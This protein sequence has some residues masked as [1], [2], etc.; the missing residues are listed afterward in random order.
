[1]ASSEALHGRLQTDIDLKSSAE[2]YYK[3]WRKEA[4]KIPTATGQNIQAITLHEGDWHD[5][6]AIK[7]WNYTVGCKEKMQ[8]SEGLIWVA[9]EMYHDNINIPQ[10]I[11]EDINLEIMNN[12]I[13]IYIYIYI[14]FLT[15]YASECV[16]GKSGVFKEKVEF[17]D[18]SMTITLH[19]IEGDVYNEYKVYRPIC[20]VVPKNRGSVA[21]LVIE[22]ERVNEDAPI[23]NKF[24]DLFVSM[25]KDIDAHA[26]AA[27][28]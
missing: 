27:S 2:E 26:Y 13:Y 19:G 21:K 20:K 17:D 10:H 25:T 8:E 9:A 12:H 7:I 16:D 28:T 24:M 11:Y 14:Q 6:G 22:Y 4:H 15:N 23:P 1:M 18:A 5:H 3:M